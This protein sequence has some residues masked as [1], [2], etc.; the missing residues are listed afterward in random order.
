M[1]LHVDMACSVMVGLKGGVMF[2]SS[3]IECSRLRVTR[4]SY[5]C[6]S[7]QMLV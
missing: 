6:G 3:M 1:T 7:L 5:L 2:V 4:S